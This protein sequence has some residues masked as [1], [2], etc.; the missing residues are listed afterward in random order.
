[1]PS[2]L[3]T[4]LRSLLGL[5][6]SLVLAAPGQAH[7]STYTP[8]RY[9][10]PGDGPRVPPGA[11][12][13]TPGGTSGRP[14]GSSSPSAPGVRGRAGWTSGG[15]GPAPAAAPFGSGTPA[16]ALLPGSSAAGSSA[17]GHS[18][19]TS[20]SVWWQRHRDEL[21][22]VDDLLARRFPPGPERFLGRERTVAATQRPFQLPSA[23]EVGKRLVPALR[24]ALG[25][26]RSADLSSA[27]LIALARL[28]RHA[29]PDLRAGLLAVL[30]Q[31]CFDSTQE[32]AETAAL[33]LGVLG[34]P[35][36]LPL[37]E[38]LLTSEVRSGSE[39]TPVRTRAF[40]AYALGLLRLES[41]DL[42]RATEALRA[43]YRQDSG[44]T[45]DVRVACLR[46]LGVLGSSRRGHQGGDR[47]DDDGIGSLG[48]WLLGRAL[49][50]SASPATRAQARLALSELFVPANP[51]SP[52]DP[53]RLPQHLRADVLDLLNGAR[54]RVTNA[55]ETATVLALGALVGPGRDTRERAAFDRLRQAASLYAQPAA[56][57]RIPMAQ[58][59]AILRLEGW[60]PER[61]REL[62]RAL[63]R[64][65]ARRGA[66]LRWSA[67]ALGR[68]EAQ[69]RAAGRTP[70]EALRRA[71]LDALR[72]SKSPADVAAV[73][74]SLA[75]AR[76]DEAVPALLRRLPRAGTP[77]QRAHLVLTIAM[78]DPRAAKPEAY[79]LFERALYHPGALR[80]A[81]S[82]LC[83]QG[84]RG[85]PERLATRM[86]ATSSQALQASLARALGDLGDAASLAPLL[87]LLG[88]D[89]RP[90]LARAF[91]AVALGRIGARAMGQDR[92][93]PAERYGALLDPTS[94][95]QT[96]LGTRGKGL[97]DIL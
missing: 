10:G 19:E 75:L 85:I 3:R 77:G 8:P 41:E 91:A 43:A 9:L 12:P 29:E 52:Q 82:A 13:V 28:G 69:R 5:L 78:L 17:T 65:L 88:D 39:R 40:A 70:D 38:R 96:M 61:S 76:V 50:R 84:E 16:G 7:G 94:A 57:R 18:P 46:A 35:G 45:N 14:P 74:A 64:N 71:L 37:L 47:R 51:A 25:T 68:L 62:S 63:Y 92:G 6:L 79:K 36:A 97:L 89:T 72:R 26:S 60:A 20:W 30:S 48:S 32:I 22:R 66:E 83:L 15:S 93:R 24:E 95:P 55:E 73:A 56:R 23:A 87:A 67:L 11:G 49:D 54:L 80:D 34:E 90:A 44:A 21:L 42:G 58:A 59:D 81:A 4:A 2:P 31:R 53:T 86:E 33:S 1:M 27:C